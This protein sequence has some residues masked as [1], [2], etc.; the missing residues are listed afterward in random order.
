MQI[1]FDNLNDY[2]MANGKYNDEV[3]NE[4]EEWLGVNI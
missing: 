2:I 3:L 4:V 1:V